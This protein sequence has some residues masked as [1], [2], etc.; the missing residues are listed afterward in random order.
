MSEALRR[1]LD[2]WAT[3]KTEISRLKKAREALECDSPT[4]EAAPDWTDMKPILLECS[5]TKWPYA[6]TPDWSA[7]QRAMPEEAIDDVDDWCPSCVEGLR[8]HIAERKLRKSVGGLTTA[9]LSQWRVE[10]E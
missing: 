9:L 3:I 5:L 7:E 4:A 8:L 1:K 10:N 2:K 6:D